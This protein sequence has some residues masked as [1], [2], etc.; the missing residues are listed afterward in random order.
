MPAASGHPVFREPS[1]PNIKIWRYMDFTKYV[2]LLDAGGLYFSRSDLLGDPFEGSTTHG[3]LAL[4]REFYEDLPPEVGDRM[5]SHLSNALRWSRQWTFISSWHMNEFESAAMWSI[6]ASSN[7]AI[8]VQSTYARLHN[9]LPSDVYVGEVQ[10]IDYEAKR[11]PENNMFW[12]FVHK[13][14]SYEHERELRAIFQDTSPPLGQSN[15]EKGRLVEVSIDDL[16]EAVYVAPTA[17]T[18]FRDLVEAVTAKYGFAHKSITRSSLDSDP[19][20]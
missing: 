2:S 11:M 20:Y 13:R 12:P 4:R 1:N 6:Y 5:S 17:P 14:K 16:V 9:C 8:A 15:L 7:E 19:V 18:W 3:N 10:Y